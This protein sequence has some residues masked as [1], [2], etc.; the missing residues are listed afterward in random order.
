[1][2]EPSPHF[3][4]TAF[5]PLSAWDLLRDEIRQRQETGYDVADVARR[6]STVDPRNRQQV[7]LLLDELASLQ[8]SAD[9]DY[10]EPEGVE[11]IR[12]SLPAAP[13][14]T[15]AESSTLADKIHA[16]WLGR[17]AGCNLGKP[18]E[19]GDYWTSD[20]IK[21]YLQLAGAYPLR[22]YVPA[23]DP[24]PTGFELRECWTE[25]TLGNVNGSSRD[26]DIDY[27]ILALHLLETHGADLSPEHVA[28][29]WTALLP[30]RQ[31][32]TAERAAYINITNGL[33]GP[34]IAN[35]RNPYR[36][37]IGAQIRGDVYGYVFPGDPWKAAE[38]AFQDASLSHVANGVYGEMWAA[39]L[40][41][42]AFTS[43]DASE[44]VKVSLSVV[45]PGSR[46]AEAIHAVL[47][48]HKDG[49]DWD[50]ALK[51]IQSLYGHYSWVH[52]VNNAA[53]VVAGLLWGE[54]DY[55]RSVGLTV[56]GGWDT[57]SNGA[58]VGSVAG[59]L[60]GTA[61]L[62][63]H[64]IDPLQDR[65]RSALFGFDNARISDLAERTFSLAVNGLK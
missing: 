28:D 15:E 47:Q 29:A 57:D 27:S 33:T 42:A 2:A 38:L 44:A 45:P 60:A 55:T 25:T 12:E 11:A 65:V 61:K 50:Q 20:H 40:I 31:V 46:L 4:S 21:A 8:R 39:A 23:L 58:T 35:Y 26:D 43:N 16:A 9:W 17:I 32:F 19:L 13:P 62:P 1:M 34:D 18:V 22:D 53:L 3:P 36:E 54:G 37:W 64:L 41:S 10:A 59:I 56:M 24:M 6:A 48:L 63:S 5:D 14:V 49:L 52:T 30:L 51:Q 7:L